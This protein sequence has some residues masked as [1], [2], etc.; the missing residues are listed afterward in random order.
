MTLNDL[1]FRLVRPLGGLQVA[2]YLARRHPRILMYHRIAPSSVDGAIGVDQFRQQMKTIKREFNPVSL[3]ALISA[4]YR[5]EVPEN[6]VAITFDDGYADFYQYAFPVIKEEGLPCTLFV[7]TGFV[8]GELWLWPDRLRFCVDQTAR[9]RV[10]FPEL[11]QTLS[12]SEDRHS[13]WNTLADYCLTLSNTDKSEFIERV[14][15][16][17]NVVL[18]TSAPSQYKG[19]TWDQVREIT[20]AGVEIGSHSFSHP[21]LTSLDQSGLQ[22]ELSK[23]RETIERE[24]GQLV[25]GFCYP[26]GQPIDFDERVKTAVRAAGYEYAL[27]AYP[28]PEPL[29]DLLAIHRYP[30]SNSNSMFE[31]TIFGFSYLRFHNYAS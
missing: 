27:A 18:P 16:Q 8:S 19:L 4:N 24:T 23:S 20:H 21:I 3:D 7:T 12:I 14:A 11:N 6:A 17:L 5:N 9:D 28:G 22:C 29:K 1:I 15:D 26:N 30:G 2:K 10:S 13:A 31:K 25:K